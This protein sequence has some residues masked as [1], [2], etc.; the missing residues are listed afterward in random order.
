MSL[1]HLGNEVFSNFAF[2]GALVLGKTTLMS[3]VTSFYRTK[4]KSMTSIEDAKWLEPNNK[5]KQ[6]QMLVPNED[7]ERVR[8]LGIINIRASNLIVQNFQT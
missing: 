1:F 7:V 2:Y 4:T 8:F 5:E 3:L 6:K